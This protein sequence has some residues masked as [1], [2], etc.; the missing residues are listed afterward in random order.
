MEELS[1][2]QILEA[3]SKNLVQ[4][5]P[6][7]RLMKGARGIGK[8]LWQLGK[9]VAPE[10]TNPLSKLAG[11]LIGDPYKAM[12]KGTKEKFPTE[13]EIKSKLLDMGWIMVPGSLKLS[14]K[15]DYLVKAQPIGGLDANDEYIPK[16]GSAEYTWIIDSAEPEKIKM[17]P[18]QRVSSTVPPTPTSTSTP[19]PTPTSTTTPSTS[20]APAPT[21]NIEDQITQTL[22][23]KGW[24][25]IPGTMRQSSNGRF[26]FVKAA[27]IKGVDPTTG[28]YTY[29]SP[30][31]FKDFRVDAN[32]PTRAVPV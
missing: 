9:F 24:D 16:Q 7:K 13:K 29:G 6:G 21:P 3:L 20:A 5:I 30:P 31:V 25:Y 26:Y 4:R 28:D 10:I 11:G 14:K 32:N 17:L 19:T 8:G 15:G 18:G 23:D 1:Q 27:K 2:R 22:E 12:K